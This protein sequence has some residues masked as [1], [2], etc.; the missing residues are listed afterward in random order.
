MVSV[1]CIR[2]VGLVALACSTMALAAVT[3][4][5]AA[6]D[7]PSA[8]V[9]AA[10]APEAAPTAEQTIAAPAAPTA[11]AAVE[12]TPS[13]PAEILTPGETPAPIAAVP[14]PAAEPVAVAAPPAVPVADPVLIAV[15]ERLAR[16][17]PGIDKADQAALVAFYATR[18]EGPAWTRNASYTAPAQAVLAT[19]QSADD[20][21][22]DAKAFVV[23][24]LVANANDRALADADIALSAAVLKYARQ[25]SGG[26]VDPST[27]SRFNDL[28]GTFADPPA[29][30]AG[31]TA[32]KRP[33]VFLQ[34]LHP[35]N[36]Q[37]M[38]LREALVKARHGGAPKV[39]AAPEPVKLSLA[40]GPAVKP[41]ASHPDVA[42]IRSR[43]AIA[44]QPRPRARH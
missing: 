1:D 2:R 19:L 4:A 35:Q 20:W 12:P 6:D 11:V 31:V 38:L 43:F 26:R 32:T 23:P 37:F 22:L 8:P 44:A 13:A 10:P 3:S 15:R 24:P 14:P 42:A 16:P 9:V 25:A 33:D 29:V 27:L 17:V 41:G 30:I 5:R 7:A 40:S 36:P 39:E 28:R 18:T 21:G 34:A